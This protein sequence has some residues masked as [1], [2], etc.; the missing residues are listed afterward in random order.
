MCGDK[1]R[2]IRKYGENNY[3]NCNLGSLKMEKEIVGV[4]I[5]KN[6]LVIYFNN[7]YFTIINDKKHIKQWFNRKSL[8]INS[9]FVVFEPTGGYEKNL[10]YFLQ[11]NAIS[12]RMVHANHV[13]AYTKALGILAKTD[14]IDAKILYN[15]ANA[16][17]LEP[18]ETK[19]EHPLIKNL[20]NRRDQLVD[21]KIEE[22]NRLETADCKKIIKSI[23]NHIKWLKKQILAIEKEL[24]DFAKNNDEIKNIV[25]LYTS[26]PGV[27]LLTA[28]RLIA[29]LPEILSCDEKQIAGLVGLAP[30]NKDSGNMRGRRYIMAGRPKIRRALYM[31]AISGIRCNTY[32][33]AFYTKLRARGKPAKV[34]IIACARKLLI[35]IMSIA[36]RQTPWVPCLN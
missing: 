3:F 21:L 2:I 12:M 13:R 24:N 10:K 27:G 9:I 4:D 20:L 32:L 26:I 25:D 33:K 22:S 28:L 31:A 17:S 18:E 7:K 15:Y 34:A 14:N 29:D 8:D 36:K 35:L 5:A 1:P 30:M 16:V 6:D 23:N 19:K 11:D